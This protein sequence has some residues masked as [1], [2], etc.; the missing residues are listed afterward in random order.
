MKRILIIAVILILGTALKA[1]TVQQYTMYNLNHYIVNPAAAGNENYADIRMGYRKQWTGIDV[2]P[3]TYYLSGH[4]VLNR[5]KNYMRSAVRMSNSWGHPSRRKPTI[6]HAVGAVVNSSEF[7]AFKR[8]EASG[9]YALHL[10]VNREITISMGLS[11]GL[12]SFSFDETKG[13]VLYSGDPIYDA[14]ATSDQSNKFNANSGI[15]AYSDKFYI[16]YSTQQLIRSQIGLSNVK[17]AIGSERFD[18]HHFF[19]AGYNYDVTNEIRLS[20]G[21]LVKKVGSNPISYDINALLTYKQFLS[22]GLAYRSQDAVSVMFSYHINGLIKIGYS[23]DYNISEIRSVSSG[24]NELFIGV[25][26][27]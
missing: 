8:L 21:V 26:I 9:S 11:A 18:F 14:Y 2:A 22:G 12:K 1:Q 7:G 4:T 10:P 24:S 3:S 15:Y 20:P 6:K 23:Y 27:F 19:I 17:M 5:P 13:D 25:S 16:G